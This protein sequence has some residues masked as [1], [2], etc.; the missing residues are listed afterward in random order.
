MALN[1]NL[2]LGMKQNLAEKA[3]FY[4]LNQTSLRA[5][6]STCDSANRHAWMIERN[7]GVDRATGKIV[8]ENG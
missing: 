4:F 8:Q 1:R 2:M 3:Y 5:L 6:W 7:G